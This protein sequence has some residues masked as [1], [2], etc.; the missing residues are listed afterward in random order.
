MRCA[1]M[2]G[3]PAAAPGPATG[4]PD[5]QPFRVMCIDVVRRVGTRGPPLTRR[6]R[7]VVA[8]RSGWLD[9]TLPGRRPTGGRAARRASE[10]VMEEPRLD[11]LDPASLRAL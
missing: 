9:R 8:E 1:V 2:A 7:R 4:R 10:V 3:G 6:G 11:G 5:R